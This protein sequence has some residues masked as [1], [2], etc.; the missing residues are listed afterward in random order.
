[1]DFTTA[2]EQAQADVKPGDT[3]TQTTMTEAEALLPASI[4]WMVEQGMSVDVRQTK[5]VV[6]PH[7]Y[8]QATQRHAGQVK[9][10]VES[11]SA[12]F[13]VRQ[14]TLSGLSQACA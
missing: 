7:A 4:R 1:L 2:S 14:A 6:L 9:L 11:L 10:T 3:I 5:Q 8:M 12:V 13:L